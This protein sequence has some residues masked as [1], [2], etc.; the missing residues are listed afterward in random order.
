MK[1]LGAV[2]LCVLAAPLA[3]ASE[4]V[5][6]SGEV[7]QAVARDTN[8]KMGGAPIGPTRS[9]HGL[10]EQNA[11]EAETAHPEHAQPETSPT[12]SV[13]LNTPVIKQGE[14]ET[15]LTITLRAGS[16]AFRPEGTV[17][18]TLAAHDTE[19]RAEIAQNHPHNI[20][21]EHYF[22][23]EFYVQAAEAG[24]QQ[25]YVIPVQLTE[26][27]RPT[28]QAPEIHML[29]VEYIPFVPQIFSP[30][31]RTFERAERIFQTEESEKSLP[32]QNAPSRSYARAL[33]DQTRTIT[34]VPVVFAAANPA[35]VINVHTVIP[36]VFPA[37]V[38]GIPKREYANQF[39]SP[40]ADAV[41]LLA[42][43]KRLGASLAID[44]RILITLRAYTGTGFENGTAFLRNLEQLALPSFLLQYAD[45]D[46]GAQAALGFERLLTPTGVSFLAE[47]VKPREAIQFTMF[48]TNRELANSAPWASEFEDQDPAGEGPTSDTALARLSRWN[49]SAGKILWPGTGALTP[50]L[51]QLAQRSGFSHI[52]LAETPGAAEETE[53][54]SSENPT[55]QPS[56]TSAP[57][58][59]FQLGNMRVY[60]AEPTVQKTLSQAF[61][62]SNAT[63]SETEFT[64]A[65]AYT[66]LTAKEQP[67]QQIL[68]TLPRTGEITGERLTR[69]LDYFGQANW[70][71]FPTNNRES[72][73]Y[74]KS[75]ATEEAWAAD[76]TF[77]SEGAAEA[78]RSARLQRLRAAEAGE[79]HASENADSLE[80]PQY[81]HDYIRMRLLAFY[82]SRWADG[83]PGFTRALQQYANEDEKLFAG[84]QVLPDQRARIFGNTTN[85]P[86]QVYNN[87]PFT[88][89]VSATVTAENGALDVDTAASN[90][91][92]TVQ[93]NGIG[94]VIA[95]VQTRIASGY[96]GV[97]VQL[98]AV[99]SKRI[100]NTEGVVVA[101]TTQ[102]ESLMIGGTVALCLLFVIFGAIRGHRRKIREISRVKPE[103]IERNS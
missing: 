48:N 49:E 70:M 95:R 53:R 80:H 65:L 71:S 69:F 12:L 29:Q 79:A 85:I 4:V 9:P 39:F 26:I 46:A 90:E 14:G 97:L 17:R 37:D 1:V 74:W 68:F 34:S 35:S 8:T 64:R 87:L 84:V 101:I 28:S 33:T 76:R 22:V 36:L 57:A 10:A 44:P 93:P 20:A 56:T 96:S 47:Q 75:A 27:F 6:Q 30:E 61:T 7:A 82:A 66:A 24:T 91:R 83:G 73:E 89:R 67:N 59:I 103:T 54:K 99:S 13:Q 31:K 15:L 2:A 77:G 98:S 40:N 41:K 63:V 88:A 62:T 11:P 3:V 19:D 42:A 60:V 23:H 45:A 38:W 51:A 5:S 78:Q 102:Y 43:A 18:I 52:L 55:V 92:I 72:G 58:G 86:V 16:A 50:Q 81:L 21:N 100:L 25:Q 32:H 94:T